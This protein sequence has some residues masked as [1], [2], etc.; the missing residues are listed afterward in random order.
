MNDLCD[1]L[2][3]ILQF[4]ATEIVYTEKNNRLIADLDCYA[5]TSSSVRKLVE[6]GNSFIITTQ[7]IQNPKVQIRIN[8]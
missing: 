6:M 8:L 1:R 3:D 4:E 7:S 5:I 2:S